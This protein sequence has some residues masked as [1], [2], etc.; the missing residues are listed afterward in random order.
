VRYTERRVAERGR[1]KR[2]AVVDDDDDSREALAILLGSEGYEV[3]QY[4]NGADALAAL[5]RSPT[6]PHLIIFDLRMPTMDGW[7]FRVLQ[8]AEPHLTHTPVIALSAERSPQARAIDVDEFL[9]KPTHYDKILD[10]VAAVIERAAARDRSEKQLALE[11]LAV[12]GRFSAGIAHEINNPLSGVTTNLHVLREELSHLEAL[13][14]TAG[15]QGV[16]PKPDALHETFAELDAMVGDSIEGALRIGAIV[17]DLHVFTR[18]DD[19]GERP[20]A[21]DAALDA[22]IDVARNIGIGHPA[23]VR[24]YAG[25]PHVVTTERRLVHLFVNLLANAFQAMVPGKAGQVVVEAFVEHANV[26]VRIKDNGIGIPP[27]N[28]ARIFEPFFTTRPVGQGVG[29]GL[30]VCRGTAAA[31]GGTIGVESTPGEGSTFTVTLP[32]FVGNPTAELRG[33]RPHGT[34]R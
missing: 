6:A 17:K 24:R 4:A 8:K 5:R 11:S 33:E 7:Q 23:I 19:S 2:I 29:L 25:S 27:E 12:V 15:E 22:A 3:A 9:L 30:S 13:L 28:L 21:V 26:I 14:R 20:V 32:A 16:L 18:V 1:N 34:T 10:T 31:A